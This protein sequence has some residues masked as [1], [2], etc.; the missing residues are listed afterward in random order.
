MK[1]IPLSKKGKHAGKY[2]AQVDDEDYERVSQFNWHIQI[3]KRKL[4]ASSRV[5]ERGKDGRK[6]QDLLHRYIMNEF[7]PN[8]EIDHK[9]HDGLNCQKSNMRKS[10]SIQNGQNRRAKTTGTSQYKGVRLKKTKFKLLSGEIKFCIRWNAQITVDK[11]TIELGGFKT[12]IEAAIAYDNA[13][14]KYFSE[15]ANLNFK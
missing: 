4:Y 10:N 13:A 11:I 7:D 14:K 15:F 1:L 5:G 8:I 12:E 9:D 6:K 2:F 3:C